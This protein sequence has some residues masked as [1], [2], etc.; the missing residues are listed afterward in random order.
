MSPIEVRPAAPGDW[1]SVARI[2]TN[3]KEAAQWPVG[4]YHGQSVLLALLDGAPAGFCA[5]RQTAPDEA[6]LL[7]LAVD[8]ALRRKG[9][10]LALLHELARQ[11]QGDMFLEVAEDNLPARRLY[12]KHG[13][14]EAGVRRGYYQNGLVNGIVMKK[15]SC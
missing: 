12:L 1:P 7:N 11:T 2:Q 15:P 3:S 14:I 6:E 4:D 5:F 13:F 9:V 8:P 10:A